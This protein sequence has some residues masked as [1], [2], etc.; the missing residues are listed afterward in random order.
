[1]FGIFFNKKDVWDFLNLPIRI[2]KDTS[3]RIPPLAGS[4]RLALD[5]KRFPFYE[6][7]EATFFIAR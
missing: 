2:N 5:R 1:M 7:S 4:A 3:Q 6:Y